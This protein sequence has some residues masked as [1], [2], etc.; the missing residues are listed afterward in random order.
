MR[1]EELGTDERRQ[2]EERSLEFLREGG[3][4]RGL[5]TT[6]IARIA[7][8]LQEPTARAFRGKRRPA[9]VAVLAAALLV[10][11]AG[12]ALAWVT[13][14][15][16]RLPVVG[17]LEKLGP[18]GALFGAR[19]RSRLSPPGP[20][21]ATSPTTGSS[22]AQ[23]SSSIPR[24]RMVQPDEPED[25]APQNADTLV[26][27]IGQVPESSHRSNVPPRRIAR[28]DDGALRAAV[29]R[30]EAAPATPLPRPVQERPIVAEAQS[31]ALV[32][33]RWRTQRD[34]RAALAS[35]DAH[36]RR[37]S[38]GAMALEARLLRVEVLLSERRSQEALRVLDRLS[39]DEVPRSR[40]LRTLRGELR[41]E[42]ERCAD[43]R[44]DLASIT[45]EGDALARRA[46]RALSRCLSE[47]SH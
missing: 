12:T 1:P 38:R 19:A 26:R 46:Q 17:K 9:W 8:R 13:N 25:V 40:E 24:A 47:R 3:R 37:F 33:E 45:T 16:D 35:L 28:A 7:A 11:V 10:V 6:Q 18:L 14:S 36:E 43:A 30:F 22:D 21:R 15:I 42:L 5:S 41:A 20:P 27:A 32:L 39:L 23:P 4:L 44:A 31:F 34:A 2:L 29:P